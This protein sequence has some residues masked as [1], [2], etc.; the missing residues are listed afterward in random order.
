[1]TVFWDIAHAIIT[2][3]MEAVGTPETSVNFCET[4][5]RNIPEDSHLHCS[6]HITAMMCDHTCCVF[7]LLRGNGQYRSTYIGKTLKACDFS[8]TL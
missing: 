4:T 3:M 2:L 1:M 8:I 7:N 5:R 6:C